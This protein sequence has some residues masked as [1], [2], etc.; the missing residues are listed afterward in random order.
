MPPCLASRPACPV[1]S[2]VLGVPYLVLVNGP[3]AHR[4]LIQ[5]AAMFAVPPFGRADR[6]HRE[7]RR[8]PPL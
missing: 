3:T 6:R 2:S 1:P 4:A 8:H 7:C 5:V